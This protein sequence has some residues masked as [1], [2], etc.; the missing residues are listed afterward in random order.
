MPDLNFSALPLEGPI[1]GGFLAMHSGY[2]AD[3]HRGVDIAAPVGTP[4][5]HFATIP[6]KLYAFH[7]VGAGNVPLD[8]WGDGSLGNCA[9]V[10]YI[11]TPWFGYFAHLRLFNT[12]LLPGMLLLP[13]V[14]LGYVGLT[15]KTSGPHL[16]MALCI[17]DSH[18]GPPAAFA[19]PVLFL[20]PAMSL[21]DKVARLE[22]IVAG[23]GIYA[24]DLKTT[25]TGEGAL[26]HADRKQFSALLSAQ[27]NN[28]SIQEVANAL[29]DFADDGMDDRQLR[30]ELVENLRNMADAMEAGK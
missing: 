10:D 22:R 5:R 3:G 4:V 13:G 2:P 7:G 1:T 11:G 19:D 6:T 20:A 16:H 27:K 18:S 24:D 12:D 8:G 29:A 25:L 14:D 23:Y 17:N 28:L 30:D 9:V 21:E 26:K 15:G